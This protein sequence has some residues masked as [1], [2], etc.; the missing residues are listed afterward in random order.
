MLT[1]ENS[2]GSAFGAAALAF[3]EKGLWPFSGGLTET[4][5]TVV[6][7]LVAYRN[8]WRKLAEK[9]RQPTNPREL[10]S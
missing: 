8:E 5:A 10:T 6:D 3:E 1:S 4:A 2:E 7:G 9:G